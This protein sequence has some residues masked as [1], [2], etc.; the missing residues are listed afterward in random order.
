M[1]IILND[2]KYLSLKDIN[3]YKDR[4]YYNIN[5]N[6]R[7]NGLFIK[8]KKNMIIDTNDKYRIVLN[9]EILDLNTLLSVRYRSFIKNIDSPSIEVIRNNKTDSIFNDNQG[10]LVLNF[11]SI[12]D[13]NYPKIHILPWT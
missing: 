8:T 11:M 1:K 3:F 13:N 4:I 9:K 10:F 12:N 7:V 6:I 5:D 2:I